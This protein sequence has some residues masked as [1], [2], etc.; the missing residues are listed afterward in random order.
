MLF[1]EFMFGILQARLT[2]KC[3]ELAP[4][5]WKFASMEKT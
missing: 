2:L 4:L 1:M 5:F 3:N